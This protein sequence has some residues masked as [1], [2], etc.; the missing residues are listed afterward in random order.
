MEYFV[1][2]N[3]GDREEWN[4]RGRERQGEKNSL[5]GVEWMTA[6]DDREELMTV[7]AENSYPK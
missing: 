2:C 6:E 4:E 7:P 5:D 1:Y 3:D